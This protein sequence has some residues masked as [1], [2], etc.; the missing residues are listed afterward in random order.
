MPDTEMRT[1]LCFIQGLRAKSAIYDCLAPYAPREWR[2]G[3]REEVCPLTIRLGVWGSVV[4]PPA[5]FYLRSESSGVGG[6]EGSGGVRTSSSSV[7]AYSPLPPPLQ[8]KFSPEFYVLHG[9]HWAAQGGPDP[10]TPLPGQ[11]RR[12]QKE[13]IWN[14]FFS[15]FERCRGPPT[16]RGPGK[17]FPPPPS[18]RAWR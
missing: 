16:S 3:K 8:R 6:F 10:W 12:C 18:R 9:P 17:L 14:T 2:L 1:S 11:L 5:W 4:T 15:I 13:T 7:A